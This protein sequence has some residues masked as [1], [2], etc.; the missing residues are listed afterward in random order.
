MHRPIIVKLIHTKDK[1]QIFSSA[2]NLKTYNE[3]RRS[4]DEYSPYVYVTEH[5]PTKFQQQG[6]LLLPEFKEAKRNKQSAYWRVI[7]D[8]YY[9]FVDGVKINLPK[10][11][12]EKR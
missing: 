9:L 5:L 7:D 1:P 8:N 6:K 3:T 10:E 11:N 2:K 12:A 4:Y